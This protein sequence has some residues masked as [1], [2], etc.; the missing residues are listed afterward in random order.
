MF[1]RILL[2]VLLMLPFVAATN[3]ANAE[4]PFPQCLP[5]P[6]DTGGGGVR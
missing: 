6:E 2:A 4:V 5:C 3:V 1:K